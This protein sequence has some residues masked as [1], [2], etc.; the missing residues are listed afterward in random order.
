MTYTFVNVKVKQAGLTV[1]VTDATNE[2]FPTKNNPGTP[3][4][5]GKRFYYR[6]VG[7]RETKLH[8]YRTKLGAALARELKK[9]N[10]NI[11]IPNGKFCYCFIFSCL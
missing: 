11:V 2:N 7:K 10:R 4:E 1:T 8:H 3:D 6:P 5:D 9:A